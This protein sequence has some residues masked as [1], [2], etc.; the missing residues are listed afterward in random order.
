MRFSVALEDQ[1]KVLIEAQGFEVRAGPFT[2]V[3]RTEPPT[4]MFRVRTVLRAHQAQALGI[5]VKGGDK[6]PRET[7]LRFIATIDDDGNAVSIDHVSSSGRKKV[8]WNALPLR[9]RKRIT[10]NKNRKKSL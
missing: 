2:K 10:R 5:E 4:Y 6:W 8:G 1:V 7:S 9:A 3:I